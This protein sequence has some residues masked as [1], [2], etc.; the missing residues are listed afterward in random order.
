MERNRKN[1]LWIAITAAFATFIIRI[2]LSIVSIALPTVSRYFKVDMTDVSGVMVYYL[3]F[4]TCTMLIFGKLAD[5]IGLK[6]ILIYGYVLFAAGSFMCIFAG[7]LNL[8]IFFRSIQGTG[9]AMFITAAFAVIPKFLPQ[10]IMGWAFGIQILGT[11]LGSTVAAPLGGIITEYLSWQCIFII[12]VP[13]AVIAIIIAR[14]VLPEEHMERDN[15]KFDIPGIF[16]SFASVFFLLYGLNNGRK[17]GW[18]SPFILTAFAASALSF[19]IFI[20]NEKKSKNPLI[21]LELFKNIRFN[22]A[23]FTSI[24]AFSVSSGIQFIV[25]FYLELVHSLKPVKTGFIF[26]IYPLVN[27][28]LGPLAGRE[29]DKINPTTIITV[30][31]LLGSISCIFFAFFLNIKSLF[32]VIIFLIL[33]GITYGLNAPPNNKLVMSFAPRGKHGITSATYNTIR[34]LSLA[35]GVCIFEIIFSTSLSHPHKNYM[36]VP[37][38]ELIKGFQ[39]TFIAGAIIC[40]MGMAAAF[41]VI[42]AGERRVKSE[43]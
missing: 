22:Y 3:L 11:T 5:S 32:P 14:R 6:K 43:Q 37:F 16:L 38:N 10:E 26:L 31:M 18:T 42:I 23:I 27:M 36:K 28:L 29:A 33:I 4:F 13:V 35:L 19:T 8:L 2:D 39:N 40:F 17:I 20:F 9:A 25:P 21:D 24:M 30:S 1:Y 34:N 41:I 7:N 15:G 12:N